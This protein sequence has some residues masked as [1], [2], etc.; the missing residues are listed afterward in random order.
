MGVGPLA[1]DETEKTSDDLAAGGDAATARAT[2]SSSMKTEAV[3]GAVQT[4]SGPGGDISSR[5]SIS[6][7]TFVRL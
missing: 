4:P 7:I 6:G 5:S 2:E 1:A 3:V